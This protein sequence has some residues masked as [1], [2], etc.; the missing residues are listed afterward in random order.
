MRIIRKLNRAQWGYP[1][2]VIPSSPY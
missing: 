1:E 2:Q